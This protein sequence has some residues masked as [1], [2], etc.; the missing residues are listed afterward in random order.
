MPPFP[1]PLES[2]LGPI[3][4]Y[5]IFLTIGFA[6][7]FALEI[8]GFADSPRLAAQFYFRDLT[9][10]KVMFTAIVVAM[11]LIFGASAV[12][13]LDYNLIWV[14]PTY[15]W[16]GIVGGLV[17]GV[18]FIVG[19]Y[20]PGTS[21]VAAATARIDGIFFA[22]G[23]AIGIFLF[24]ETVSLYD[25]FWTSSYL[26]RLTLP[27]VFG[28]PTGWVVLLVVFMA[29]FMFW[30]GEKLEGIFGGL[31]QAKATKG[32][33]VGALVLVGVA[34]LVLI[35]GQPS[36]ED[37]WSRIASA[38][39]ARLLARE[40]QATPGEV[41]EKIHDH[42]LN[43]RLID[44]RDEAD[45]N[46]F[47]LSQAER[48][49]PSALIA[50]ADEFVLDPPNTAYILMSNDELFSTQ[51]WKELTSLGVPNAYIMA[52]GVNAWLDTFGHEDEGVARV[53]SI[54]PPEQLRYQ[55]PAAYGSR[56]H[57]AAPDPAH[58]EFEYVPVIEIKMKR[59]PLGSGCG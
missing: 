35:L 32:R 29:L 36:L 24:G 31:D 6:F 43:V 57:A 17:M 1:I 21:I 5:A 27:E 15:L 9:V 22:I 14:N 18:G 45:F 54:T 53:A 12:G 25:V 44:I 37:R 33:Y 20:C 39:E 19:G 58:Y 59:G 28:I 55:F 10:L 51:A 38:S 11:V 2:V 3:G 4:A 8:A 50:H 49:T 47:H 46:L 56:Y 34:A 41:L 16:P 30:G 48:F 13:S 52:G 40:V 23:T 42:R 26:G 7:G